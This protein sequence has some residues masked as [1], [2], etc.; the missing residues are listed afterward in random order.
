MHEY[1]FVQQT[2]RDK[3]PIYF[4]TI[5]ISKVFAGLKHNAQSPQ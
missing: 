2:S 4:S 1:D 5:T 3:M